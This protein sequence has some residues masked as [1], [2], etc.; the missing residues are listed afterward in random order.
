MLVLVTA[1][2]LTENRKLGWTV[3]GAWTVLDSASAVATPAAVG[4]RGRT[5]DVRR[6]VS[7]IVDAEVIMTL[8]GILVRTGYAS[9][10]AGLR[11]Y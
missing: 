2:V 10:T 1:T 9:W 5:F 7:S 3:D 4:S 8:N 11:C 6:A